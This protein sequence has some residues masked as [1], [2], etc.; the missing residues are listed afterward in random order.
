[1][2]NKTNIASDTWLT[3]RDFYQE[4]D[5][6]FSFD[7]F[8][9]CPPNNDLTKFDGLLVPW[10]K[11]TYCNPP[12]SQKLKEKFV[13]K[14]YEES[15]LDKLVVLLLPVSTSTKIFHEL[16]LPNAKIEYIRSRLAFEGIDRSGAWINPGMGMYELQGVPEGAERIKRS[17]QND[18][19]LVIFGEE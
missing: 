4:L 17:G 11:R 16:I 19:M 18:N 1:M 6:R 3:P 9:P 12:Y 7:R 14:A 8:D 10:A 2:K 15:L 13:W 5:K